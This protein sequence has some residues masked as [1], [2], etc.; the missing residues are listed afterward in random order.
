MVVSEYTSKYKCD[1]FFFFFWVMTS[2]RH[3][4]LAMMSILYVRML[5]L[6]EVVR[7]IEIRLAYLRVFESR[8]LVRYQLGTLVILVESIRLRHG[9]GRFL[10]LLLH[11]C[12]VIFEL[13]N[14]FSLLLIC[15]YVFVSSVMSSCEPQKEKWKIHTRY[16]F[17]SVYLAISQPN[18]S[19]C[20]VLQTYIVRY[21]QQTDPY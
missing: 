9:V 5:L 6:G 20:K 12:Q 15:V 16:D 13:L 4:L 8:S 18:D 7:S 21:H 11:L 2:R 19:V 10:F 1:F 3:Y 14:L 17:D